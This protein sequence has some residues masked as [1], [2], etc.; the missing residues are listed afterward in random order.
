[1]SPQQHYE[2]LTRRLGEQTTGGYLIFLFVF[3]TDP[4][5]LKLWQQVLRTYCIFHRVC[6]KSS[7]FD[8]KQFVPDYWEQVEECQGKI[9]QM[10]SVPKPYSDKSPQV[11]DGPRA[12][13]PS[14][15]SGALMKLVGE[16]HDLHMHQGAADAQRNIPAD[17]PM[18]GSAHWILHWL[19][20]LCDKELFA[21]VRYAGLQATGLD[22][23][24]YMIGL[25]FHFY[26]EEVGEKL[27]HGINY[28]LGGEFLGDLEASQ[29]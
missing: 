17:D 25:T 7:H 8:P 22:I 9:C 19:H 16:M 26:G 23:Q 21:Q 12:P 11:E 18:H 14:N 20:L 1:M 24:D 4:F 3:H 28:L 10:R 6:A 29:Y 5:D 27:I 15:P 2:D 13:D